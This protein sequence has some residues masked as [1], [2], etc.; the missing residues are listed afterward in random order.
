MKMMTLTQILSTIGITFIVI[1]CNWQTAVGVLFCMSA[2]VRYPYDK[3]SKKGF[4]TD[5]PKPSKPRSEIKPPP[6]QKK[7]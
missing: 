7:D 4:N 5:K 1:F 2:C 3:S 6:S